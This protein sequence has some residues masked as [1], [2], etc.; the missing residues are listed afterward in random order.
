MHILVDCQILQSKSRVKGFGNYG[1]R[2]LDQLILDHEV[3]V[4]LLISTNGTFGNTLEIVRYGKKHSLKIY[5]FNPPLI[6][7]YEINAKRLERANQVYVSRINSIC[8]DHLLVLAPLALSHEQ[9]CSLKGLKENIKTAGFF[10][11]WFTPERFQSEFNKDTQRKMQ[12]QHQQLQDFHHVIAISEYAKNEFLTKHPNSV[13]SIY[14]LPI[15]KK[16]KLKQGELILTIS[17]RSKHK[18]LNNLLNAYSIFQ[19]DNITES[20]L[21]VIGARKKKLWGLEDVKSKRVRYYPKIS[22]KKM[23][24]ILGQCSIIVIP[25]YAEG[26]GLPAIEGLENGLLPLCSKRIATAEI[27]SMIKFQFDPN[28]PHEISQVLASAR[29]QIL[30]KHDTAQADIDR[31]IDSHNSK[32]VLLRELL[33]Q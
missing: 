18:N 4:S 17:G 5:V 6:K 13:V 16:F 21:Y 28:V 33:K 20:K 26:L 8:P 22:R 14:Y 24:Q 29:K 19:K 30:H 32:V 15:S 3:E 10:Y 23:K 1:Y 11:D 27:I 25:S 2:V 12:N 9:T 7:R 31:M